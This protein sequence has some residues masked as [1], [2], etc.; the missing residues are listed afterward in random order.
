MPPSLLSDFREYVKIMNQHDLYNDEIIN[1]DSC[2][3]LSPTVV[4]PLMSWVFNYDKKI[5][6]HV[7]P[8][9]NE[10]LLKILG[11]IKHNTTTLPFRRIEKAKDNSTEL[12]KDILHIMDYPKENDQALKFIFYELITNV[13]DHSN[14]NKG[15]VI[16]QNYP[17]VDTADFCFMDNGI[18]IPGSFENYGYSF[19]NDC[20]AIIKAINGLSTKDEK[21][22]V[23]RGTGLN[24]TVSIVTNG[25]NGSVLIVSGTGLVQVTKN[26][27][28]ARTIPEDYLKGTLISL[29]LKNDKVINIYENLGHID[30]DLPDRIKNLK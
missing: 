17:N 15:F 10:H 30:Y 13:Y 24:N 20:D 14:F 2:R 3:F 9:T 7:N 22:Y 25:G 11:L 1:I 12:T 21:A 27:I 16:G 19:D 26:R 5:K 18:S 29:R 8:V 6:E 28:I 23:D 4:L